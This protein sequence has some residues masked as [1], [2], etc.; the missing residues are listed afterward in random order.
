M[1]NL[2]TNLKNVAVEKTNNY[3]DP[4]H[5]LCIYWPKDLDLFDKTPKYLAFEDFWQSAEAMP[6][7]SVKAT[8]LGT[9]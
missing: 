4:I 3:F 1:K 2:P 7:V 5:C 6:I 9:R 8:W